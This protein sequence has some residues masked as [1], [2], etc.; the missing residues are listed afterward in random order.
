MLR[1]MVRVL[2]SEEGVGEQLFRINIKVEVNFCLMGCIL[3]SL[4]VLGN[5]LLVIIYNFLY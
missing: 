1:L 4:V 2:I 5:I 3:C